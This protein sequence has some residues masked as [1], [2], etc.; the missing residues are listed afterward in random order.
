MLTQVAIF[1]SLKYSFYI[2]I[3]SINDIETDK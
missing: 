2:F 1:I 3:V